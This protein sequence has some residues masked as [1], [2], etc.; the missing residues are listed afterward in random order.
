MSPKFGRKATKL[1]GLY[2]SLEALGSCQGVF[3]EQVKLVLEKVFPGEEFQCSCSCCV[4]NLYW[5]SLFKAATKK[6]QLQRLL[7]GRFLHRMLC[8]GKAWFLGK[9]MSQIATISLF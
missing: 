2:S 1:S 5:P 9:Y 3:L 7:L 6:Q 8:D 4:Q